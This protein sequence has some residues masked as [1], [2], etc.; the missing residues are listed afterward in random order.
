MCSGSGRSPVWVLMCIVSLLGAVQALPQ[1]VHSTIFP[2]T[3]HHPL[4]FETPLPSSLE[5]PS[6]LTSVHRETRGAFLV[7]IGS[8]EPAR[9][10]ETCGKGVTC[11]LFRFFCHPGVP[12]SAR[13]LVRGMC[14]RCTS[15]YYV[16]LLLA[17]EN[18]RKT[19]AGLGLSVC[20]AS[21]LILSGRCDVSESSAT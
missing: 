3:P 5:A 20:T 13:P 14:A 16:P 2:P 21:Y 11:I 7:K 9:R 19:G 10:L 17:L 18:S 1:I 6:P 12:G 8:P 15:L 4:L